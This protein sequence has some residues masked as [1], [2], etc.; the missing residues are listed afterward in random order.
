MDNYTAHT[1]IDNLQAVES[2]S[3]LQTQPPKRSQWIKE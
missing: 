3:Y 1:R 2:F